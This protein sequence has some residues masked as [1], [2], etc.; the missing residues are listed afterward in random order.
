MTGRADFLYGLDQHC[1]I[2]RAMR[3]MA[4]ETRQRSVAVSETCGLRKIRRLMPCFPFIGPVAIWRIAVTDSAE[5]VERRG[6]EPAGVNERSGTAARI[7]V[8]GS[9]AMAGFAMNARFA[10]LNAV[11]RAQGEGT[12]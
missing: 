12:G 5:I 6:A 7:D 8:F 9:G 3:V 4:G 10:R 2:R 11:I 1:L